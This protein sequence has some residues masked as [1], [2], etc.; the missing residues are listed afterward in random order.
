VIHSLPPEQTLT[1]LKKLLPFRTLLSFPGFLRKWKQWRG[2]IGAIIR[3]TAESGRPALT[4]ELILLVCP[5][6]GFQNSSGRMN[7]KNAWFRGA[8]RAGTPRKSASFLQIDV[9]MAKPGYTLRDS[10]ESVDG[11]RKRLR[12]LPSAMPVLVRSFPARPAGDLIQPA[13]EGPASALAF[14][15]NASGVLR[16]EMSCSAFA[17]QIKTHSSKRFLQ[18]QLFYALNMRLSMEKF[19]AVSRSVRY[20]AEHGKSL[21]SYD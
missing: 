8:F 11:L 2:H 14:Q 15:T 9:S 17:K 10:S 12:V 1:S 19:R 5:C 7:I 18:R 3:A 4:N 16:G 21:Y 6:K 20:Q 13:D